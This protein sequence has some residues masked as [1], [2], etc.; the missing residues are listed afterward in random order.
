MRDWVSFLLW[1]FVGAGAV[2]GLVGI[3]SIGVFVLPATV[4]VLVVAILYSKGRGAAGLLLGLWTSLMVA[5][6]FAKR[7]WLFRPDEGGWPIPKR[8]GSNP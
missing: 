1:L 6:L 4:V 2:L 7:G 8:S 5:F 3:A